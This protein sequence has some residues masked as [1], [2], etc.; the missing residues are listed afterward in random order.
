MQNQGNKAL[1]L[2]C[3]I[4]AIFALIVVYHLGN[5]LAGSSLYRAQHLGTALEYARGP[6]NLWQPVIPG[7]NANGTP[8][9][10]E[11]PVWQGVAGLVFKITGS[12]WYG[13]ANVVSLL[14]FAA[15]L[16]PFFQL[17]RPHLGERAAWWA[18]A[19]FMSEPLI[20]VYAGKAATDGFC[21]VVVIWFLFFADRMFRSGDWRWWPPLVFSACL[22]AVSKL[23]FFMVAGLVAACMLLLKREKSWRP[24][25]LLA[26]A[27][28]L[29]AAVFIAWSNYCD[30][31]VAL[32]EYPY[33]E[34]RISKNPFMVWW[35]FGDLHMRLSPGVWIKGG[36]RFLDA[37]LG[38]LPFAVILLAALFRPGNR[39][40]KFWL[41]N[42]LLMVLIFTHLVL[43]HWHY[44]LI[45]CPA[46]AMLCGATL[47]RWE[48][49]WIQ[50]IPRPWLRLPLVALLLVL[51][52]V[53]GIITMNIAMDY[54]YFPKKMSRLIRQY[55]KPEDKLII[56]KGDPEWPGEL[57]FLSDRR[58]FFVPTL[59]G[60]RDGPMDKGL[61]EILNN[62]SELQRLKALGYTKLV[63][64][65]QS[66]VRFAVEASKPGSQAERLFY[67]ATIS[68][69]VDAWPVVYRSPDMLIKEIP[70]P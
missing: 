20:V 21:L 43:I 7:F 69:K 27:G 57:L 39:L 13:W 8:T 58:G 64:V 18:L 2:P 19:F 52:A 62:E 41:L 12:T 26:G 32:A 30:S 44:Y 17:V 23:P 63:L 29:A 56:L 35:F 54:D 61:Q 40:A 55:T 45:C 15:G 1:N 60:R 38:S 68:P 50:E 25:V 37:T 70:N 22:A 33:T 65:S 67:P 49:F 66:P 11:F 3:L 14:F 51:S 53:A 42:T 9:P 24:W 46:V 5:A 16:W 36:W 34:L 59:A 48:D 47:A 4:A 10:Q 6:I 31:M 28:G